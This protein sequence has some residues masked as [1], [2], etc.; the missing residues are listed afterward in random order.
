M[1]RLLTKILDQPELFPRAKV[2]SHDEY[3]LYLSMAFTMDAGQG[4]DVNMIAALRNYVRNMEKNGQWGCLDDSTLAAMIL[5]QT[6]VVVL[7]NVPHNV[8]QQRIEARNKIDWNTPG[9]QQRL[10]AYFPDGTS[11][12]NKCLIILHIIIIQQMNR[13]FDHDQ[14]NN[15]TMRQEGDAGVMQERQ[16]LNPIV[17]WYNGLNHF[18]T[19]I[20]VGF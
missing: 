9:I 7:P 12:V 14:L 2:Q 3:I 20:I 19:L 4:F 18:E 8:L 6:I 17:L 11:M 15:F 5:Q 13:D 1:Y 10:Q 16:V